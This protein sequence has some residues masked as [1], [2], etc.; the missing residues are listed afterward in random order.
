[1]LA[2]MQKAGH[3]QAIRTARNKAHTKPRQGGKVI[4]DPYMTSRL[5]SI[6]RENNRKVGDLWKTK[7]NLNLLK[8]VTASISRRPQEK[9]LSNIYK[10][11]ALKF[12]RIGMTVYHWSR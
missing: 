2:P 6:K 7:Q 3:I 11:T 8:S 1:M 9:Q 12:M 5:F 4:K 10:I